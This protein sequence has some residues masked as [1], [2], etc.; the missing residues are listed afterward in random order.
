MQREKRSGIGMMIQMTCEVL[1]LKSLVD[2]NM[3]IFL[4][5]IEFITVINNCKFN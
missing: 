5:P 1:L 3:K 2:W 4:F